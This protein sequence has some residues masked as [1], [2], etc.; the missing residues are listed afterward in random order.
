MLSRGVLECPLVQ[1]ACLVRAG[2]L[3]P[4]GFV[5]SHSTAQGVAVTVNPDHLG[6]E[7]PDISFYENLQA[8]GCGLTVIP[9][10]DVGRW[11]KII[12][13]PYEEDAQAAVALAAFYRL[14][15]Q[16]IALPMSTHGSWKAVQQQMSSVYERALEIPCVPGDTRLEVRMPPN[17]SEADV[18]TRPTLLRPLSSLS[19]RSGKSLR[20]TVSSLGARSN[21]SGDS[22][23]SGA[24]A[25]HEDL[26]GL[27]L[28]GRSLSLKSSESLV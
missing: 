21:S 27:E 5:C 8:S 13:L 22:Q 19:I 24:E 25:D 17:G 18:S 26:D 23:E 15:F 20:T 16:Q 7:F 28:M 10:G 14:V 2:T 11:R 3:W 9:M 4:N 1:R 6:F 12:E